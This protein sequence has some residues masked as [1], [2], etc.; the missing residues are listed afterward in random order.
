MTKKAEE[1]GY[2][3]LGTVPRVLRCK[4]KDADRKAS[5]DALHALIESEKAVRR[6]KLRVASAAKQINDRLKA[7]DEEQLVLHDERQLEEVERTVRCEVRRTPTMIYLVRLDTGSEVSRRPLTAE[8]LK[9]LHPALP[10]TGPAPK[11]PPAEL[12]PDEDTARR[13]QAEEEH[14]ARVKELL[15]DFDVQAALDGADEPANDDDE[16]PEEKPKAKK[17]KGKKS[18]AEK[19]APMFP[20]PGGSK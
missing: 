17:G 8:E 1:Q 4:V 14:A 12:V 19:T 9:A 11:V 6:K 2:E 20:E 5:D 7:L 13:V 10:G 16:E 18:A 15:E 3:A